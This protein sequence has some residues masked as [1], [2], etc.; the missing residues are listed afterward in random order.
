VYREQTLP[1]EGWY[2]QRG[3]LSEVDG[4][5]A[6]DLVYSDLVRAATAVGAA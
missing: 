4:D 5:R 2:R 1:L 6:A 3:L